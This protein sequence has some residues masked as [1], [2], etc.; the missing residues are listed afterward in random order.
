MST[1][2]TKKVVSIWLW[3]AIPLKEVQCKMETH[4]GGAECTS[5]INDHSGWIHQS[6]EIHEHQSA[7]DFL[8]HNTIFNS[9][10]LFFHSELKNTEKKEKHLI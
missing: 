10:F 3:M 9:S 7:D 2:Q 6:T 8:Q 4:A 1:F 5:K